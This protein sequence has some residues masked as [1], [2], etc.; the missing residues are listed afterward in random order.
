M[1]KKKKPFT[2]LL[3]DD[4]RDIRDVLCTALTDAGYPVLSAENGQAAWSIFNDARPPIV[5]TDIKMPVMDGIELLRRIKCENPD[6]EVIM[7]T[8]HGD[9]E[10]AINSLK[11]QACDFI[12]KPINVSALEMALKRSCER[13]VMRQKLHEY[14]TNLEALIREKSQLQDHLSS[15]GL[16]IGSISHSIKGLLTG[17]DGGIYLLGKGLKT[18]D[19]A[20][21]EEGWKTVKVMADRIRNMVMDILFYAKKRDLRWEKVDLYQFAEEAARIMEN[22]LKDTGI[23]FKR[24]FGGAI[25]DCEIDPGYVHAALMNLFDNAIDACQRGTKASESRITF[26]VAPANGNIS[27]SIIDNG[28]GMDE[29]TQGKLFTLFF[30]S[31]G[32]QG[33]GLGLYITKNIIEQ[34]GG[35]ISVCSAHGQGSRFTILLPIQGKQLTPGQADG[36]N[37]KDGSQCLQS[38]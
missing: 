33:T 18:R 15:L 24:D 10:L 28:I 4:E 23:A 32:I 8:G 30:S 38:A 37:G 31:K 35:T 2:V 36:K 22:R 3:V 25:D 20:Q 17:L 19:E 9:I 16:M 12:T 6:T 11:H 14:T 21:I 5:I 34:H 13:I 27:F 1:T 7:I 29:A 26:A